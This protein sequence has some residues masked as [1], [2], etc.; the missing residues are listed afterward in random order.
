MSDGDSYWNCK[1]SDSVKER[2]CLT[3]RKDEAIKARIRDMSSRRR[4]GADVKNV[5]SKDVR[6][7]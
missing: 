5:K 6:F 7:V 3:K 2:V 1:T 4:E